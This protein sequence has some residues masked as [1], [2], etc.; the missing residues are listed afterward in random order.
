MTDAPS[1]LL[2]AA[3]M[4]SQASQAARPPMILREHPKLRDVWPP[5]PGGAVAAGFRSPQGGVDILEQVF[6]YA[7]VGDATADVALLTKYE[8]QSFTRDL[9]LTDPQFAKDLATWLRG[10]IGKSVQQIGELPLNLD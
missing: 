5:E 3:R 9:L 8:G 7:P 10:Q 4:Q 1:F 6:Y 2:W